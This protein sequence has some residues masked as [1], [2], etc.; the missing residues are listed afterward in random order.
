MEETTE[1]QAFKSGFVNIIG[2]PNVGKSTLINALIGERMSIISHKPQTTRHRIIGILTNEK[3][4]M[5]F[6]DTPG[7]IEKPAY[8]MHKA[9]NKF[10]HSA[11][12][13]A[14]IFLFVTSPDDKYGETDPL[15]DLMNAVTEPVVLV[16]N[17]IDLSNQQDLEKLILKWKEKIPVKEVVLI[18]ALNNFNIGAL[19]EHIE[20][21]LPEGP[22]YFPADQLTDRLERFFVT[23]IIREKVFLQYRDEIPYTCE[24]SIEE[25]KET[26]TK[27]GTPIARIRAILM[28]ERESQKAIIL[29]KQ[30]MGIK[31]LGTLS[32]EAIEKFI[33]CKV[34]LE[35]TIKIAPKWRNSDTFL[36]RLGYDV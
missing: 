9:M 18:S 25:Y 30:G 20:V 33:E 27:D 12:E 28:V 7:F 11:F 2:K 34:Y 3:Y 15:I 10:V 26:T 8:K 4:Q 14:D 1:L 29:G 23:E 17:K 6:S 5:V 36:K 22:M 16:I 13:D 24:V 19:L 31:K 21:Y 32:R 35:I